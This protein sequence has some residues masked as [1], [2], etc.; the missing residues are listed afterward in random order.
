MVGRCDAVGHKPGPDSG[1]SEVGMSDVIR[2]VVI[3][4]EALFRRGL[5]SAIEGFDDMAVA[6]AADSVNDG[7]ALLDR[8]EPQVAMVGTT[9]ADA[10]GLDF[11]GEVRRRYPAVATIVMA[12]SESRTTNCFP[13]S[14]PVPRVCRPGGQRGAARR[15]DPPRR[16]WANT[17]STSNS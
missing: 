15:T 4:R 2:V 1:G 9:F 13:P 8:A 11:A 14:G 3:E 10:P 7:Y 16:R 12:A 17:S 6:G 5:V